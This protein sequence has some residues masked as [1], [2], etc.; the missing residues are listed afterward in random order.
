MFV[1]I[2]SL[3]FYANAVYYKQANQ[4]ITIY[5]LQT[6]RDASD[7]LVGNR[8]VQHRQRCLRIFHRLKELYAHGRI[9]GQTASDIF[10]HRCLI[11]YI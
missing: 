7:M 11:Y 3:Y 10:F 9:A 2:C 4:D 1:H 8:A 6:R 5:F